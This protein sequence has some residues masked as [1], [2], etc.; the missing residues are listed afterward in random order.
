MQAEVDGMTAILSAKKT[1]RGKK[2]KK[3][4]RK[5]KPLIPK[6]SP[7]DGVEGGLQPGAESGTV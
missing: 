4:A 7:I 1:K 2:K 3:R 5:M 6:A